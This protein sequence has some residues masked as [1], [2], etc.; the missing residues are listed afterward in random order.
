MIT[1]K[2]SMKSISK[3]SFSRLVDYISDKQNKDNRVQ[4]IFIT[5]CKNDDLNW[6]KIEIEATQKLN[7]RATSD[8]T[9]HL[10][11]S[12]QKGEEL[13]SELLKKIESEICQSLGYEEHQRISIVHNDTDNLHIHVAI[14]KIH[15]EK[16]TLHEPYR[17]YYTRSKV[18][19]ELEEKYGLKRD[20]HKS[21]YTQSQ[22]NANDMERI[23]GVE[24]LITYIKRECNF[25]T[26]LSWQE[27]HSNL[28]DKGLVIRQR[29]NG[30][31]IETIDSSLAVKA[32]SIGYSKS[33]LEK[34]LGIFTAGKKSF[35][36]SNTYKKEPIK[37]KVDT[38]K[39]Y[40]KY[41]NINKLNNEKKKKIYQQAREKRDLLIKDAKNKAKLKREIIKLTKNNPFKKNVYKSI[42][43]TLLNDIE[44]SKDI[45]Q[46][47]ILAAK[48][49][50]HLSWLDWLKIEA[51]NNPEALKILKNRVTNNK[52]NSNSNSF[53]KSSKQDILT[54][55][56]GA[57]IDNITKKGNV[58]YSVAASKL[59]DEGNKLS[60]AKGVTNNG[61][62][63]AI[64]MAI[65]KYGNNLNLSGTDE[66]K[67][68]V[69]DIVVSKKINI[70]FNDPNIEENR[71][72]LEVEYERIRNRNSKRTKSARFGRKK[73]YGQFEY[74][75][76]K[77][78]DDRSSNKTTTNTGAFNIRGT[79]GSQ[80]TGGSYNLRNLSECSMDSL[81]RRSKM[82]LSSNASN[83]LEDNRTRSS[84][85]VRWSISRA[86][87]DIIG[88]KSDDNSI[89]AADK[90]IKSRNEKAK[91]LFDIK[92]H[93]HYN[94]F[95][96]SKFSSSNFRYSGMRYIDNHALALFESDNNTI[97]VIPVDKTIENKLRKCSRGDSVTISREGFNIKSTRRVKR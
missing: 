71:K 9:Y 8:K 45:Y 16:L 76:R 1:K 34:K 67:S 96:G 35:Y 2:V 81:E 56:P 48:N 40:E 84:D 27:L 69:I 20:N 31:I 49:L 88:I 93:I 74:E 4:D 38:T 21:K 42:Y 22:S 54:L 51:K 75:T 94:E 46:N 17:D 92:K 63:A 58:I 3:S 79:G 52:T 80:I 83:H 50:K 95:I 73:S 5:N 90:Y 91:I 44:K 28:N 39:L 36:S 32:S 70:T 12:F 82:L 33:K 26:A 10:L 13:S 57:K 64:L 30:L 87:L 60:V 43:S 53:S 24:S 78:N 65:Y 62:Y 7:T 41:L 85:I 14:N 68:K 55:I 72:K 47:E 59:I 86:R 29:G 66:F 18:C 6:A 77:S 37:N 97:T 25:E 23:A 11:I 15:P 89:L 19:V 61:L